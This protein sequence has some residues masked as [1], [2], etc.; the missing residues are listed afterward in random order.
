MN[1]QKVNFH[2]SVTPCE[3]F[4]T[5][6]ACYACACASSSDGVINDI[7]TALERE[8]VPCF[9]DQTGGM[10]MVGVCDFTGGT[11]TWNQEC[12]ILS[13]FAY[14]TEAHS[15][16]Y[17][18]RVVVDV[19]DVDEYVTDTVGDY[20]TNNMD[21]LSAYARVR[22]VALCVKAILNLVREMGV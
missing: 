6:H 13:A 14:G 5:P 12:L 1:N 11:F 22:Y 7:A 20:L 15:E 17:D 18:A 9:I 2:P 16:D 21:V 8:G 4:G 10:T 19:R 3:L